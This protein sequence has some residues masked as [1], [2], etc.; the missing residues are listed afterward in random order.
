MDT[1]KCFYYIYMYIEYFKYFFSLK[2]VNKINL[3]IIIFK[4]NWV[5]KEILTD[6]KV[7]NDYKLKNKLR[8]K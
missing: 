3:Y 7:K 8:K 4:N 6:K 1:K 5:N 2:D